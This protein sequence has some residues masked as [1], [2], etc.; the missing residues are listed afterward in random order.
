MS[1]AFFWHE[2]NGTMVGFAQLATLAKK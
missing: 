2:D 1:F